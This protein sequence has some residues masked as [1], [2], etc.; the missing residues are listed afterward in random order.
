MTDGASGPSLV[1][2]GSLIQQG[3]VATEGLWQHPD[4]TA[5]RHHV[6]ELI[7]RVRGEATAL[8]QTAMLPVCDEVGPM[9]NSAPTPQ[10]VEILIGGFETLARLWRASQVS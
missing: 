4:D 1:S 9:A 2:L 3:R 10:A 8:G 6:G 5:G 7:A